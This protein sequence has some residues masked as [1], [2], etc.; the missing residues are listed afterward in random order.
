E[1][2]RKENVQVSQQ[3]LMGAVVE[4]ARQYPG[5][6]AQVI[7]F[8]RKNPNHIEELRGPL[9]EDKVVDLIFGKVKTKEQKL[10][11]EELVKLDADEDEEAAKPAKKKATKKAAGAKE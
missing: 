3:E 7:E 2:G 6:E 8:Y 10:S 4:Q 1:L 11:L 5:Q 9:F